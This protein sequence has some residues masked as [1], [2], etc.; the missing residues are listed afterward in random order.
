MLYAFALLHSFSWRI[1]WLKAYLRNLVCII[2]ICFKL[3]CILIFFL[4]EI[5]MYMRRTYASWNSFLAAF[6]H[7][8]HLRF[9]FFSFQGHVERRFLSF[10]FFSSHSQNMQVIFSSLRNSRNVWWYDYFLSFRGIS[11]AYCCFLFVPI[12]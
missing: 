4:R 8:A 10:C 5:F 3:S 12:L 1:S 6:F 9:I 7:Y 11:N 2:Y